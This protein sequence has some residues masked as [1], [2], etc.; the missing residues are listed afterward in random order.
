MKWKSSPHF[1]ADAADDDHGGDMAIALL[2]DAREA[3]GLELLHDASSRLDS[4]GVL[5][6][7]RWQRTAQLPFIYPAVVCARQCICQ[8]RQFKTVQS[9]R[10]VSY[11]SK[12]S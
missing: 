8:G 2:G 11:E 12:T 7:V 3:R 10:K 1:H 5:K 4:V 9:E 6:V